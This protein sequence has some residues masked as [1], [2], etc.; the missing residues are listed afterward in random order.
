MTSVEDASNL[1]QKFRNVKLVRNLPGKPFPF[2][3]KQFEGLVCSSVPEY[4]GDNETQ[5]QFLHECIM[6]A[7]KVYS[8][9][10]NKYFEA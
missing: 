7:R 8:T 6:A 5:K 1:E 2:N 4:I 10:P 9:T 3:G